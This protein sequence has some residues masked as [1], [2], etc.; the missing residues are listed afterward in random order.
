MSNLLFELQ[1][2][3]HTIKSILNSTQALDDYIEYLYFHTIKSILNLL[4]QHLNY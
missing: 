4:G 1:L 3:F 2:N